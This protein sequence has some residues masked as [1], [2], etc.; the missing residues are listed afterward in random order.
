MEL[1]VDKVVSLVLTW[2]SADC[3]T[4]CLKSLQDSHLRTEIV[5]VDNDSK[6]NTREII[7]SQFPTVRCINTRA[8]LGY[9]GG[10]NVGIKYA[11]EE[12]NA[13]YIFILNPDATIDPN[14]LNK[15]VA[16]MK[17]EKRLAGVSP[18]IYKH[19][20]KEIWYAGSDINW[21]TG[22]TPHIG[23]RE[24]DVNKY[25]KNKYTQRLNGCAMLLRTE[26]VKE[27]GLM[28][29]KYFLYYEETDWSVRFTKAG[30]MLGLEPSARADHQVSTSTGGSTSPLY[31]YYMSR[32]KLYFIHKFQPRRFHSFVWHST[33]HYAV[34]LLRIFHHRGFMVTYKIA[35]ARARGYKD[36]WMSNFGKQDIS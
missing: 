7:G 2:N 9:A 15:L 14:C 4:E 34:D 12:L 11:L 8:N 26:A 1:L 31:Q 17:S 3:I 18:I 6:D 35:K 32:N 22:A 27:V 25:R 29:E 33:L 13:T 5:V 10:N 19:G 16:R 28:D 36:Y 30:Y 24:T 23:F 20:S 21:K